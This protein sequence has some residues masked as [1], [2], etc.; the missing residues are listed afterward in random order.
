MKKYLVALL[1]IVLIPLSASAEKWQEG[2]HY[3]VA[4]VQK[5]NK[6]EVREYFSYYCPACRGFEA[7]LP[8]IKKA[9]PDNAS[10]KKT[11]VDFMGYASADIQF[12]MSTAHTVAERTGLGQAFSSALFNH[13]QTKR[14]P[15]DKQD[16]LKAIYVSVGGDA[17]K[18]DKAM[19]SFSI[20][21]E[22]KR[23]KKVQDVLSKGRYLTSVPTF[24]VN[25]KYIINSKSLEQD[26]FINE[27]NKLISY[28]LTLD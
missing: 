4:P 5:T 19:K 8:E 24:I 21:G 2:K 7:Y 9:L 12:M 28:L 10:L 27:Y 25:G 6:A 22:A 3:S 1:A 17:S 11:H 14:L 20:V 16:D 18:F 26:D 13:L 15:V 23:N